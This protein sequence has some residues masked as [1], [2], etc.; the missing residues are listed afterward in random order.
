LLDIE[1]ED[2]SQDVA[3]ETV[4]SAENQETD[5]SKTKERN[6]NEVES[7]DNILGKVLAT[8]AVRR[9]ARENNVRLEDVTATGKG[10]RVLKEDMLAYLQK[11]ADPKVKTEVPSYTSVTGKTVGLK[12]YTKHMWKTMTKSLVS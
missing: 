6:V 2:D 7:E 11:I 1:L 12:G 5:N 9:I 3:G 4:R 10:G 8:P